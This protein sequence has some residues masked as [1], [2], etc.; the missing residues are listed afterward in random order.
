MN[1]KYYLIKNE[2][3]MYLKANNVFLGKV[4]ED[5]R[6]KTAKEAQD[7]ISSYRIVGCLVQ[8]IY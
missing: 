8:A 2:Q 7:F 3:G 1:P 6:F 4:H 5:R